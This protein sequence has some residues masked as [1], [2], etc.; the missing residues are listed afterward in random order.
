MRYNR[1]DDF[2]DP[3]S[4]LLGLVF[5]NMHSVECPV[6]AERAGD[7]VNRV[8]DLKHFDPPVTQ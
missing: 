6:P 7:V 8:I 5:I 4:V 2:K 3:C 1:V